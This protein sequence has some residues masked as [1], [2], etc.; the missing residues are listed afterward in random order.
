MLRLRQWRFK[1]RYAHAREMSTDS[2]DIAWGRCSINE[3][4]L[5]A[6]VIVL[7]PDD[8]EDDEGREEIEAT[9]VHELLHVL[10]NG[11]RR[12]GKVPDAAGD[13]AEEQLINVIS[14]LLVQ[15]QLSALSRQLSATSKAKPRSIAKGGSG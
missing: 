13:V 12:E 10:T 7:H 8:Y 2:G 5:R 9:V 1:I 15:L 14:E 4:H 6:K 3:N 11:M